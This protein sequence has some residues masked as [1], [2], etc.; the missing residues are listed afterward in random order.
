MTTTDIQ[1]LA[2]EEARI[3]EDGELV[4]EIFRGDHAFEEQPP[5]YVVDLTDD[6]HGPRRI[7]ARDHSI[8]TARWTVDSAPLR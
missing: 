7:Y 1:R 8:E 2:P 5:F 4:A 3:F 6:P